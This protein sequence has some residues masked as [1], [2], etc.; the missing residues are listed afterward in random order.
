LSPVRFAELRERLVTLRDSGSASRQNPWPRRVDDAGLCRIDAAE[1]AA[2]RDLHHLRQGRREFHAGGT[3]PPHEV[4]CRALA[5]VLGHFGLFESAG[6]WLGCLGVVEVAGA[7]R[8]NSSCPA[9]RAHA[10]RD[11]EI[12]N[13]IWQTHSRQDAS[14]VEAT[15]TPV[16][17]AS[18]TL[19]FRCF[20]SADGSARRSRGE[21]GPHLIQQRLKCGGCGGRSARPRHRVAVRRRSRQSRRRR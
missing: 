20:S 6:F 12:T 11:H 21:D 5:L 9:A 16:T 14:I 3:P 19:R 17:S 10:G 15:S 7:Y 4:I 2:E 8:A 18:N 1:A 13:A